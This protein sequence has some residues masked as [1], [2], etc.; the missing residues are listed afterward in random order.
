M[1]LLISLLKELRDFVEEL[2]DGDCKRDCPLFELYIYELES[3]ITSLN[4]E[5]QAIAHN[6]DEQLLEDFA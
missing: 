1:Q 5:I 6:K 4:A 2:F 3:H